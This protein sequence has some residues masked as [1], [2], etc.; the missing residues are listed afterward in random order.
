MADIYQNSTRE[1]LLSVIKEL[2]EKLSEEIRKNKSI[3]SSFDKKLAEKQ[4]TITDLT[5]QI[6]EYKEEKEKE[7][8]MQTIK[9]E[10]AK[11]K[12][13][14][15]NDYR[16]CGPSVYGEDAMPTSEL[17]CKKCKVVFNKI[18]C[19]NLKDKTCSNCGTWKKWVHTCRRHNICACSMEC[20]I[21]LTETYDFPLD[22]FDGVSVFNGKP[23]LDEYH[24]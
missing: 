23:Y 22:H 3:Q 19:K 1:D 15:D 7:K 2:E 20:A 4:Q 12:T 6:T 11:K 18:I 5:K 21:E 8:I 17:L 13:N 9:D 10:E 24:L 16:S 14:S